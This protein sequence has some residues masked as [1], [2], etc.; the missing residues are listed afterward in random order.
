MKLEKAA[1]KTV[2][3]FSLLLF[4]ILTGMSLFTTVYFQADYAGEVPISRTDFFPVALGG[5]AALGVLLLVLGFWATREEEEAEKR[6]KILLS[7]VLIW[8]LAA[9]SLWVF[10][11]HYAPMYDQKLIATSAAR[12]L[13]GNY[14]RLDSGKYLYT[15]P[16][17]LGITAWAQLVFWLFGAENYL[18][19]GL[20]NVAGT[21][22]SVYAGYRITRYLFSE[23]KAAAYYLGLMG[24]CFPLL[25]YSPYVYGDV[26][27][28]TLSLLA[29]WQLLRYLRED[30]KSGALFLAASLAL[31]VLIRNN[32]L[33]VLI[34]C[35]G[36]LLVKSIVKKNPRYFLCILLLVLGVIGSRKG[37]EAYYERSSGREINS[38][39]PMILYV[40]MGMQEGDKEAGWY[41]GYHT[42]I[43]QQVCQ[44]HGPTAQELGVA[45]VRSRAKEFL[46]DPAYAFDFYYRKFNSQWNEPTYAC[47]FMTHD[48]DGMRGELAR[49][50]FE[51]RLH[52]FLEAFMDSYQLLL[53]GTT[54]FFLIR[55]RREDLP[56]ESCI[57]FIMI[58]GGALF[59]QIWEAKSRYILP[60]F[61]MMLPMAAGGLAEISQLLQRWRTKDEAAKSGR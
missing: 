27:A 5:A 50:V 41:N 18:A 59:H 25:F 26:L 53:Y 43:Y 15:N 21:A 37:L 13:E 56:I 2:I 38:G 44:F 55:K 60:Y 35:A 8:V 14:G 36:V 51:G 29:V 9:G 10:L 48:S 52:F 54:L 31:A 24:S 45:E 46:K 30:K 58:I 42:Y 34:A 1:E 57:L 61:V 7:A 23:L 39:M 19:F 28:V 40:A 17:Q 3:I 32:S 49:S 16:H 22:V 11:A 6:L 20:L 47:F 12:F 33:I 4:G